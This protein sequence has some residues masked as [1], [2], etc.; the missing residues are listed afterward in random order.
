MQIILYG[1]SLVNPT[2]GKFPRSYEINIK[3]FGE[4][5]NR[6][7]TQVYR[8]VKEAIMKRFWDREF[9][10]HD[11]YETNRQGEFVRARVK[12]VTTVKYSDKAGFLKIYFNPEIEEYLHNLKSSFTTYYIQQISKFKRFYSVRFYELSVMNLNRSKVNRSV[13]SITIEDLR[14]ILDIK[15]KYPR[16]VSLKNRV[17]IPSLQEINR[18]SDL[19]IS[20]EIIKNGRSP[21]E[22]KFTV[23][24]PKP[25]S[26]ELRLNCIDMENK[27]HKRVSP[28][29]VE[30]AKKIAFL[31]NTGWDI[32]VIEQ[33]YYDFMKLKGE[34]DN[35]DKAFIGFVKKKVIKP[36][37]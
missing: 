25:G 22:L 12:W 7:H 34:P 20:F 16:F 14:T 35:I 17:I 8:D 3:K 15:E 5:F 31:A 2:D 4:M 36:P 18:F 27:Y 9:T 13:F 21:Y 11:K 19:K 26:E 1:I 30:I 32:Y 37:G 6:V 33:Q 23:S 28:K 29:T 24:K 10:F